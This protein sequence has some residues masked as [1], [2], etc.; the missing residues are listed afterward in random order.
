MNLFDPVENLPFVGPT[1]ANRLAKLEI[2]TIEDLICHFPFRYDDFSLVSSVGRLQAGETITIKAKVEEVKNE[3]TKNGRKIQKA[4]V[5]DPSGKLDLIWFNQPFLVK[6]IKVGERFNF[7]GEV[8]WFGRKLALISPEY[9]VSKNFQT[10]HTGRLV[11]VYRETEGISSKWLRARI[12]TALKIFEEKI[13]EFLPFEILHQYHLIPERI[14]LNQI[15]FSKNNFEIQKARQRLAFD[16]LFLI[17]LSAL[18][19]KREWQ[20]KLITRPF[21]IDEEK[22][23][24]F[25]KEL[26]FELTSAQK[27]VIKEIAS[28]LKKTKPMN[29]L[30]VGDVGSGKTIV[31]ATAMYLS[32]LNGLGSALMVPTEI[33][34]NQH[35]KTLQ[36][37]FA[38]FGI[39]LELVTSSQKTK[40]KNPKKNSP[41]VLV[42]THALL[43]QKLESES[44]GLVVVDEQHRFGVRQ[45]S[46]LFEKGRSPHFLTMTA[47]PIPRTVA[48]TLYGDLDLSALDELP[49]GRL[50]IK[51]WVV[52]SQKRKAAYDWIKTRVKG[53]QEQVFIICPLIEESETLVSVKNVTNEFNYLSKEIFPDLRLGLLHGRLKSK[54]KDKTLTNFKD[55]KLDVL[56]STPV[57]EV[58]IDIPKATIMVIEEADR[59]GLAQLHQLRGRVGRSNLESYCLLFTKNVNPQVIERLKSLET[60]HIGMELAE[61]DLKLRGPGEIYGTHQHGFMHLKIASFSD[62][63]LIQETRAAAASVVDKLNNFPPLKEKLKNYTIQPINPN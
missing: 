22:I 55:G 28:D 35:F 34:A 24:E 59:F 6:T 51:T 58:G 61:I 48:L 39:T 30:L 18:K 12:N 19:R 15:H 50:K 43:Y 42:G 49:K 31:A 2:Q 1:Y 63:K 38:P 44:F 37:F 54:E 40:I 27:K 47:T 60:N 3:Y 17:Q 13:P 62:L 16:E 53:A 56:V 10:L 41:R 4:V 57:V 33:L 5:S 32:Y 29:R 23:Q 21:S 45:R 11:P 52:P 36:S 26:P 46:D 25:I 7:S 9:E 14:A 8:T 20:D